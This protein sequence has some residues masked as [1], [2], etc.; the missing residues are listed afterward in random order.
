MNGPIDGLLRTLDLVD[1]GARTHEDIFTGPS[2]WAPLGRVFGG[3]VLA[4]SLVAAQR[5]LPDDRAVHSM[6]GYFLRPGDIEQPIT[7]SVER[8]HDGR[9]FSTRRTQAYQNGLPILSMLCSFQTEDEGLDHQMPMPDGI[10]DP[11]TLPTTAELLAG[12]DHPTAAYWSNGRP[13]DVRHLPSSIYL[14][15]DGERVERQAVWMRAIGEIGDD[16]KLHRAALAYASDYSILEPVLRRHGIPWSTRGM[17]IA[18][19][20]HAMWWHRDVKVDDWLLFVQESPS[21]SGGRGLSLGRIYSREGVLVASVAQ[22]GMVRVPDPAA[23][24]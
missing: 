22:E 18:S 8:I 21:A 13:F 24:D 20:D 15:V 12:V 1:T 23:F 2:Q 16:Q 10:P 7:F 17:K 3:Q 5:T 19:L 9:S 6:H 14:E 4:Q 11:E